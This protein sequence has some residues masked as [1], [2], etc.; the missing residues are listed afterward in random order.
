MDSV[1]NRFRNG[2]WIIAA[3]ACF[4][5]ALFFRFALIGYGFLAY[6][7]TGIGILVL[8]FRLLR[9]LGACRLRRVL[10]ALIVIGLIF[11]I[12]I[13]I[14]IIISARTSKDPKADY[15]IV[16]GAGLNGSTP[17]LSM[18]NRLT[19]A[20]D[21]LEKYPEAV[22]IVSGGQGEGE[23]MTEAQ[24]MEN[25]LVARGV[26]PERIIREEKSTTTYENLKYSLEI[27]K[28]LGGDP[29]GRVAI[30]SSEYHLYRAKLMARDLGADPVGV[31]GKTSYPILRLNYFIR[32]G[33]AVAYKWVFQ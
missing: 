26:A 30:V 11:F 28:S 8:I 6:V 3:A 22:A 5:A 18:V 15:L 4:G 33:F 13:E 14:P 23:D 17:S 32:E 16:L 2:L 31:A 25:W 19:A 21:Y 10:A 27:I 20:L 12:A 1:A 24:A 7:L 9:H 29:T